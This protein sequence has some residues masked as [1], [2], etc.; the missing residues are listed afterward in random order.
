MAPELTSEYNMKNWEEATRG[1]NFIMYSPVG[2]DN[3]PSTMYIPDATSPNILHGDT[4]YKHNLGKASKKRETFFGDNIR[5]A[6]KT[7]KG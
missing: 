1:W 6:I 3:M 7:I 2:Y 4:D 5:D